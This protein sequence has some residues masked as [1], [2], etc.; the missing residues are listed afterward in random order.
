MYI[1]TITNSV[2]GKVYVGQT[3][4]SNPKMRWYAHLADTRRGKKS[5][6]YDSI[7][8]HGKE[9]FEWKIIDT[10]TDLDD[11]NR[12]EKYWLDHFRATTTVYNNRE[13]GN[14]KTHSPESIKRMKKSQ[15]L[16]HSTTNVGGWTRRD[17]GAM[18]GKAH[19]G[20]GKPNKKWTEEMKAEHSKR[21]LSVNSN[22]EKIAKTLQ[23]KGLL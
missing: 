11:L 16:R 22:P 15:K 13:A 1:Y 19:P 12:K 20:K 8:K 5:Y 18:K 17:G 6:L 3:I 14:N 21:M 10:A 4:Q 9:V 23:T 2:N 7:R